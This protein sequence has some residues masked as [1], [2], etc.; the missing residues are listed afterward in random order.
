VCTNVAVGIAFSAVLVA[1]W[2][3][4]VGSVAQRF[5]PRH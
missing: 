1:A 5:R 4:A 2:G 3:L